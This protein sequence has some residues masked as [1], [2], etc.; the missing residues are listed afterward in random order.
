[1]ER[2][3]VPLDGSALSEAIVPV[4]EALARDYGAELVLLRAVRTRIVEALEPE[5]KVAGEAEAYLRRIAE[6]VRARGLSRVSW[7]VRFAKPEHAIAEAAA[8]NRVDLITMTTHGRGGLSRLLL[9]SVAESLVRQAPAPVLLVRGQ[10]SWLAGKITRILV[11]LDLSELSAEILGIVEALAG[12]LDLAI[13]LLHAVEPI[14]RTATAEAAAR[15]E[16]ITELRR[17]DADT[18]LAKVAQDLQGKGLRARHLVR[19]GAALDVI[20]ES[21]RDEGIDLI[22]MTT[23][24][25]TGLGRLFFGSVAERVLRAAPV[26]VLLLKARENGGMSHA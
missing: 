8:R 17:A 14:D 13:V 4:A 10:P 23:H 3:L 15:L 7:S 26:P 20:Q 21:A 1:M 6:E 2:I 16:E 22:A 19:T 18:Y 24:G 5:A 11:P 9:G 25:R 12:P